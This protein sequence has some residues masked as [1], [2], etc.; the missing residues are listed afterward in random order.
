MNMKKII[1][2]KN[3]QVKELRTKLL[4]YEPQEGGESD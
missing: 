2:K 1:G 3:E 4:K